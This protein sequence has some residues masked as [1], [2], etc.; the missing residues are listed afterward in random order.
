MYI[1]KE[2]GEVE[3]V[4]KTTLALASGGWSLGL[5]I[6]SEIIFFEDKEAYEHFIKVRVRLNEHRVLFLSICN[7]HSNT[8]YLSIGSVRVSS[9]SQGSR[10]SCCSRRSSTYNRNERD[11]CHCRR[12][13]RSQEFRIFQ[14]NV[15]I[16]ST[17][18]GSNG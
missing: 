5:S 14:R 15:H 18:D 3:Q 1:R 9:W 17:K 11:H 12:S 8:F 16:C 4:G 13:W 6:F 7:F 10:S 2:D